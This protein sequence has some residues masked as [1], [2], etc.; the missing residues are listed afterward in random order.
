MKALDALVHQT[1]IVKRVLWQ[2]GGDHTGLRLKAFCS[3]A[4]ARGMQNE[5]AGA[6]RPIQPTSPVPRRS[7][8]ASC[9]SMLVGCSVA[10]EAMASEPPNLGRS[11]D[12]VT[13]LEKTTLAQGGSEL[14][15]YSTLL[16]RMLRAR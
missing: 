5:R 15:C 6:G 16:G 12:T 7:W 13:A 10:S 14:I 3:E 9:S 8:I 1:C 4:S 11:G 2:S